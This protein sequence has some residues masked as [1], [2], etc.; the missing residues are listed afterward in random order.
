MKMRKSS[1]IITKNNNIHRLYS[2][3]NNMIVRTDQQGAR[4]AFNI[5]RL[6][7]K[8]DLYEVMRWDKPKWIEKNVQKKYPKSSYE[9]TSI[10]QHP[11]SILQI[12]KNMNVLYYKPAIQNGSSYEDPRLFTYEYCI[13]C[14][15]Y[16]RS[17]KDGHRVLIF[18]IDDPDTEIML[19][20]KHQKEIEKNWCPF[21]WKGRLLILYSIYPTLILECDLLTGICTEWKQSHR[22]S[23]F[24]NH[25]YYHLGTAPI[26]IG[27][28]M[29]GMMH[30]RFEDDSYRNAFYELNPET[31]EPS[32]P[33]SWF[34]IDPHD[35][36]IQ[37]G[38]GI[39]QINDK[40]HIEL[41]FGI[42]DM[43]ISLHRLQTNELL[44]H[45]PPFSY[46]QFFSLPVFIISLKDSKRPAKDRVNEYFSNVIDI[47]GVD[48]RTLNINEWLYSLDI[49][50]PINPHHTKGEIG[51]SASHIKIWQRIRDEQIPWTI[52]FED[53]ILFPKNW[54]Q[55]LSKCLSI[56][57]A[58]SLTPYDLVYIGNQIDVNK[59]VSP[60][61]TLDTFCTHA[62]MISLEGANKI[63]SELLPYATSDNKY[64][65]I[66]PIDCLLIQEM[67]S[68]NCRLH[69]T[70]FIDVEYI[71]SSHFSVSENAKNTGL[72]HQDPQFISTV[73]DKIPENRS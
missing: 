14:I 12:N 41:I 44:Q 54:E 43:A 48:G 4:F 2:K 16:K 64:T 45:L 34:S 62:Y 23:I 68:P 59:T 50:F 38:C 17:L 7:F 27:K 25:L 60:V 53:D 26:F 46:D 29:F 65:G 52:I 6:Y 22:F 73:S 28:R 9:I 15:C 24:H 58:D 56:A 18:P 57:F 71:R 47:V 69:W 51:C 10:P 21:E 32:W 1:I 11:K 19:Y 61:M 70:C 3:T 72:V 33:S 30:R 49:R 20:Y 42:N 13:Y 35:S 5:A 55:K 63:L 39:N 37:Y 31:L 36:L 66:I 67:K 40:D 8:H